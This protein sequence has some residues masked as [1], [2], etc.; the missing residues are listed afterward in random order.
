MGREEIAQERLRGSGEKYMCVDPSL[1]LLAPLADFFS[2][3][4][5][6]H[7]DFIQVSEQ[8]GRVLIDP[9]GSCPLQ[10]LPA[11]TPGE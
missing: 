7:A 3:L 1:R 11:I 9:I 2:I 8:V 10:L 4:L 6:S 5:E